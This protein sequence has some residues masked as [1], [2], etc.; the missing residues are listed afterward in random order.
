MKGNIISKEK[1]FLCG[2]SLKHDNRRHGLFCPDHPQVAAVKS[3]IVRFGRDVQKQF[4][5]YDRA[6]QFLNGVRFKT[7]E[8]SF[9]ARDYQADKPFAFCNLSDKYLKLK[10]NLKSLKEAKRHMAVAV[11]YF[12]DRNVKE[13]TGADIED[14]LY[15]INGITEKT[16]ANYCSR[17]SDFWKW[18]LR[19][20]IIN[21]AQ[22]PLFPKIEFE[23]GYRKITDMETQEAIIREIKTMTYHVNP[24]IWLGIDLLSTYVNIR[25][26][27]LLKLREGDIDL[28]H[29]ELV[30]L[31]PTK[32]KNRLKKTRL[33]DHHIQ[34]LTEIKRQ[35]PALPDVKFFRHHGGVQSVK[36]G[37]PFGPK[38]FRIHWNAA[39]EKLGVQ[40]LDLY[41]GTRHTTTTEIARRAGTVNARKASAHET[42]SAFD[43]YCQYQEDTA[44][45]MAKIVK[46]KTGEV[47]P[48]KWKK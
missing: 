40:G 17:V 8:G 34:I 37:E 39:C 9:D 33:L 29:G 7:S 6:A 45:D 44:F 47:V 35:F 21:M 1:C 28:D 41:G 19:R 46:G 15:S 27:D 23:L 10:S 30:F 5:S 22:M 42:N 38:Y 12:G 2:G 3:F 4:R 24:K 36:P 13:I 20:G 16:R 43:R 14:Y 26:G 31:Y 32:R 48:I 25:P 18:I 11:E